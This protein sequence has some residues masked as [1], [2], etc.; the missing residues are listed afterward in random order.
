MIRW[1][2]TRPSCI[3]STF[4]GGGFGPPKKRRKETSNWNLLKTATQFV[5]SINYHYATSY[6][7]GMVLLD[8]WFEFGSVF[9]PS[10]S[11]PKQVTPVDSA[12]KQK[13][14]RNLSETNFAW[15]T[16]PQSQSLP[17]ESQTTTGSFN[18]FWD[19]PSWNLSYW[20]HWT[21]CW[22]ILFG[23]YPSNYASQITQQQCSD[24]GLGRMS[25]VQV[26][27]MTPVMMITWNDEVG[28]PSNTIQVYP[29]MVYEQ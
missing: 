19:F 24:V 8:L 16:K 26:L 27:S 12:T 22:F 7:M 25:S 29:S 4:F 9:S 23:L 2:R 18:E 28:L 15:W 14:T 17:T 5:F 3:Y 1:T 10:P 11:A 20:I 13:G 6:G 21:L